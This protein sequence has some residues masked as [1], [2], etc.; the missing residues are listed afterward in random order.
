MKIITRASA[1]RGEHTVFREHAN[2]I[3]GLYTYV[4]SEIVINTPCTCYIYV[5]SNKIEIRSSPVYVGNLVETCVKLHT[6]Y[7]IAAI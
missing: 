1:V 2:G 5:Y 6:K 7:Y 3:R 4:K